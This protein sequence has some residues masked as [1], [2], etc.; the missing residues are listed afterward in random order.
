MTLIYFII[1]SL[2]VFVIIGL[3]VYIFVFNPVDVE[4]NLIAYN[5][6]NYDTTSSNNCVSVKNSYSLL[7]TDNNILT[8]ENNKIDTAKSQWYLIESVIKGRFYIQNVETKN[9]ISI[10]DNYQLYMNN[11]S[12]AY[13]F[14]WQIN[15]NQNANYF[16]SDNNPNCKSTNDFSYIVYD[17]NKVSLNCNNNTIKGLSWLTIPTNSQL[18]S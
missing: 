13:N 9:Y 7:L 5:I 14:Y 8:M 3:I 18:V 17:N 2:L 6:Y 1:I 16:L 4:N 15:V 11:K 12:Y 10:D